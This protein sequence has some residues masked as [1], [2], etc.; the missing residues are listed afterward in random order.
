MLLL[1]IRKIHKTLYWWFVN[2]W[3]TFVSLNAHV[4]AVI[5]GLKQRLGVS[6]K[7]IYRI[8]GSRD[9]LWYSVSSWHRCWRA[10]RIT[11]HGARRTNHTR[12][13][14][15]VSSDRLPSSIRTG[16]TVPQGHGEPSVSTM[17][18]ITGRLKCL[19]DF[20]EPAWC[21][22]LERKRRGCM[23]TLLLIWSVRIIIVGDCHIKVFFG[24]LGNVDST[25]NRFVRT[26]LLRLE[27]YS[28]GKRER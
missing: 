24:M 13:A 3:M 20:S 15:K 7:S 28:T 11:G 10:A 1:F 23:W 4:L 17:E 19:K 18:H 21:L 27:C 5:D 26:R 22:E 16:P 12:S 14:C 25:L 6:Y 9:K 8:P 2:K